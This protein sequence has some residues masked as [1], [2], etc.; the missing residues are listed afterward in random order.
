MALM[1]EDTFWLSFEFPLMLLQQWQLLSRQAICLLK[2][3]SKRRCSSTGTSAFAPLREA[4]E[5]GKAHGANSAPRKPF[6]SEVDLPKLRPPPLKNSVELYLEYT[7]PLVPP[8]QWQ[9]TVEVARKFLLPDG[10]G[11]QL[12]RRLQTRAE[13]QENWVLLDRRELPVDKNLEGAPLCMAQNYG[14]FGNCRIPGFPQDSLRY[15]YG[16]A[17]RSPPSRYICVLIRNNFYL[18]QVLDDVT[19][20]PLPTYLIFHQ[21]RSALLASANTAATPVGL[22]TTL[23]RDDW[24]AVYSELSSEPS[25]MDAL[26]AIERSLFILCLDTSSGVSQLSTLDSANMQIFF[27]DGVIANN[28]L[29]GVNSKAYNAGNRWFDKTQFII[30][31]DGVV[32]LNFE[33]SPFDGHVGVAVLEAALA[34]TPTAEAVIRQEAEAAPSTHSRLHC[35]RPIE[36]V[37][38]PGL[39][40]KLE[41]ARDL[42]DTLALD[43]DVACARF[44]AFSR[45]WIKSVRLSPD[46]FVQIGL[47]L[48][49]ARLHPNRPPPA[50]YESG[51]LRRFRLGRTE[52]IRS[53]SAQSVAF[54]KAMT[55]STISDSQKCAILRKAI[56]RH[57]LYTKV[58]VSGNGFDRHLLGLRLIAADAD[59]PTPNFFSDPTYETANHFL[60]STSQITGQQDFGV[61]F[62]PVAPDGYGFCYNLQANHMNLMASTFKS[63]APDNSA[64]D[65]LSSFA[66]S[67]LDMR[68]LLESSDE[69]DFRQK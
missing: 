17:V 59:L 40:R 41:V 2:C 31:R 8:E 65:L 67:L 21:L 60:L 36:W 55:N 7:R 35:P 29:H 6:S 13:E 26:T 56:E 16:M 22:F 11:E 66:A 1:Y 23:P 25:N 43:T 63:K 4:P 57:Q 68:K 33:H 20:E 69:I 38:S 45:S 51:S 18:V 24:F 52:T 39:Y 27:Y 37:I 9:R 3:W 53:C 32:G 48:A 64:R 58:A 30:S 47:Q 15:Q 12:Q 62:G 10:E 61:S 28:S 49:Y 46:A 44:T 14:L 34:E 54:T 42:F 50:T 5:Q 19:N